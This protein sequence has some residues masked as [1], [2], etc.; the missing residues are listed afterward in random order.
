M[1]GQW[2]KTKSVG[3]RYRQHPTRKHGVNFDRYFTIR[4]KVN[5][6]EKSEGLGWASEGWTEKKAAAILAELKANQTMGLGP[7]TLTEKREIKRQE[8]E[9]KA[10]LERQQANRWTIE[11]L[12]DEYRKHL[13]GGEASKADLSRWS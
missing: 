7:A 11:K 6:L 2:I 3:V 13:P 12:W 1:A 10:E 8:D 9:A 5:G 4:Y